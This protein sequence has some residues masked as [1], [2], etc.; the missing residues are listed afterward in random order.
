MTTYRTLSNY[1]NKEMH[2]IHFAVVWS[3][4]GGSILIILLKNQSAFVTLK[5]DYQKKKKIQTKLKTLSIKDDFLFLSKIPELISKSSIVR[6]GPRCEIS[7]NMVY[8]RDFSRQYGS[9]SMN[10]S[11]KNK[12]LS[13]RC[14]LRIYL[15]VIHDFN[16]IIFQWLKTQ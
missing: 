2:K 6:Q 8:F 14:T 5:C 12:K 13:F 3:T 9:I 7:K 16:K 15:P 11:I 10:T 4:F 1:S